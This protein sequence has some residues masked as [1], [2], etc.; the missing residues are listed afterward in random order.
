MTA[1]TITASSAATSTSR[2]RPLVGQR[3]TLLTL[4][5]RY[6]GTLRAV[7]RSAVWLELRDDCLVAVTD[8]IVSVADAI[9]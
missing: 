9:D 4:R 2:L 5:D 3:V 6:T 1:S 7:H 8:E